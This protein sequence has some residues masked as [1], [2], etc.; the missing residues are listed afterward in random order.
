MLVETTSGPCQD[1]SMLITFVASPAYVS[2]ELGQ[3][4]TVRILSDA[5]AVTWQQKLYPLPT[6]SQSISYLR[7]TG[8]KGNDVV[9]TLGVPIWSSYLTR[10]RIRKI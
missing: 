3:D 2:V 10:P 8:G 1:L 7:V 9:Y 5:E 4:P 6:T